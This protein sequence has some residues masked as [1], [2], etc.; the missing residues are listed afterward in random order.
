MKLVVPSDI[1]NVATGLEY[2]GI[3]VYAIALK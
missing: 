2:E 3:N 1:L